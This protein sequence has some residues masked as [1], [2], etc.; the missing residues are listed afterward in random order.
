MRSSSGW[1]RSSAR[2]GCGLRSTQPRLTT[3]ASDAASV[4]TASRAEVPRA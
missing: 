3:Q 4:T 2:T 1:S